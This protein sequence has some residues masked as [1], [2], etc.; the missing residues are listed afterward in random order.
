VSL[1]VGEPVEQLEL[2]PS[3]APVILPKNIIE[4]VIVCFDLVQND[5]LD[6]L[7]NCIPDNNYYQNFIGMSKQIAPDGNDIKVFSLASNNNSVVIHKTRRDMP[8]LTGRR[9]TDEPPENNRVRLE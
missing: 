7:K 6:L 1:S 8:S 5:E 3:D 9:R 2:L 4:E